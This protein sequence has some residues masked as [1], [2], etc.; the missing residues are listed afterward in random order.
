MTGK[1]FCEVL[2]E[3]M[4]VPNNAQLANALQTTPAL[5]ANMNNVRSIGK[6]QVKQQIARVLKARIKVLENSIIPI[7][8]YFPVEAEQKRDRGR[9]YPFNEEQNRELA[10]ALRNAKGL[11]SFYNS[12]GKLIYVGKGERTLYGEIVQ[13]FNRDFGE[14]YTIFSVKHPRDKYKPRPDGRMRQI[15]RRHAILADT[16]AFFSAY[17]VKDGLEGLT[18]MLE[19]LMIR[20]SANNLV[21]TRMERALHRVGA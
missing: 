6:R 2:R 5:Y 12:E 16:A 1:E 3:L 4:S 19:S 18:G 13:T 15:R 8:E 7:A 10:A 20:V 14:S 17:E 21:N 9:W 11:Y